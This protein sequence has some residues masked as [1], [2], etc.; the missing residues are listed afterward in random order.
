MSVSRHALVLGLLAAS[1]SPVAGWAQDNAAKT[2]LE[3]GRYWQAQGKPEQAQQSWEK[4]LLTDPAQPEALY[5]LAAIAIGKQQLPVAQGYLDRLRAAAPD[6]RFV[7][8]LEQDLRLAVEPGKSALEKARLM[9]KDASIQNDKAALAAAVTRYDQALGGKT[10][11]GSVAREYY[12]F[13]GYTDGGVDRAIQGL[14]RLNAEQPDNPAIMFPLAQH[15]ARDEGHR[16]EGIRLL[17]KLAA[18]PDIGGA[19]TEFWRLALTWMGAPRP[20]ERPFFESYLKLHPDDADIRRQML[21][22]RSAATAGGAPSNA[23]R[24][25][26]RLA[27]GFAALKRGDLVAAERAFADKLRESPDNADALGGLGV[28]RMQQNNLP[29]A[30]TLLSRA[31]SRPGAGAN[32]G[33]ALNSARYWNLVNQ[34]IASQNAG[35]LATARRQLD[36]ALRL[37]A[38]DPAAHNALGRLYAA[39][40]DLSSAEKA[41]RAVLAVDKDNSEAISGL[42]GVLAQSGRAD[43]AMQWINGMTPTQ[44]ANLGDLGR[45]RAAVAAGRAKAA[46][47]RGDQI[48][49]RRAL[50]D[51]LHDDPNNPWIRLE[52]AR[53]YL[54]N[55]GRAEARGLVD[56]LLASN[57]DMPDALYAS[58]LLAAQMGDWTKAQDAMSRIPASARTAAM[59]ATQQEIWIHVQSDRASKLARDGRRQEARALLAQLEPAAGQ[60]PALLG[61]IAQAYVDAGD[62]SRGLSLLRPL[63]PND[64]A[65]RRPDVLLPYAGLLLKGEQDVEAAGVLREL[66][67]QRLTSD[68][69]RQLDELNFLYTVRQAELRRQRGDLAGAYDTLAPALAKRPNDALVQGALARMYA[70]GGKY[71][72]A[73]D[74]YKQMI[75]RDPDNAT[76]QVSAAQVAAQA[77]ENRYADAALERA[78][79]TAPDD[80]DVLAAAARVYRMRGKSGKAASLLESAIVAKEKRQQQTQLAGVQ[81]GPAGL[82]APITAVPPNPFAAQ[83]TR[84]SLPPQAMASALENVPSQEDESRPAAPGDARQAVVLM[85]VPEPRLADVPPP[86]PATVSAM[87]S[88]R[89]PSAVSGQAGAQPTMQND[90][91]QVVAAAAVPESRPVLAPVPAATAGTAYVQPP[92]AA[93]SAIAAQPAGRGA[94]DTSSLDVMQ[95][96]LNDIRQERSPEVLAGMFVQSHSG[97]SGTSKLTT[98]QEPV[99]ARMP[100]GEG[101]LVVR[102]TP[103][104]LNA[105]GVG[106]DSSSASQFG[107]GPVAAL[108]QA[109]GIVGGPDTQRA[110]GVGLAAG[111]E[112]QGWKA[113]VGSTPFGFE[114]TNLVG[115]V[116]FNGPIDSHQGTWYNVGA[117]RRAVTDSL[118]SF[119]G[120]RDSRTGDSWG[121]VTA[122]G[123][124]GSVG[125]DRPA[126]G[127]YGYGSWQY[128]DGTNVASNTRSEVGAGTYWYL[129]RE[130]DSMLTA[131]LNLGGMFYNRNENF[132]TYG[133]GGYFS[134][135]QFYSLSIPI[136]WAERSGRFTYKLHGSIGI[137]HFNESQAAYF[138]TSSARQAAAVDAAAALGLGGGAMHPGQSNTGVGYSA[139]AAAE[140]RLASNWTLGGTVSIDNANSY[141]QWAGGLYLRYSFYPQ[142]TRQLE[143]PVVPYS[144]PYM[145]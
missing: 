94:T 2:L 79:A 135:Q 50:E 89:Q 20:E 6:S 27:R 103:V 74:L 136:N 123:V 32:W 93:G 65:A 55:G 80:P 24:Q 76:L 1:A 142:T 121:G 22:P 113:D 132:F 53:Y 68:Q 45:L 110:S 69:S 28:V 75:E 52:L 104:Q 128:L 122:S 26:P 61:G 19:A 86:V 125:M 60:N 38:R 131:G 72:Q 130:S 71:D 133:N 119:A 42:V 58:A 47:Q 14:Q 33:K 129:Q 51:A 5:G 96:E 40:G 10:P 90:T 118:L 73:L 12:T 41:F 107:G 137:Q 44:R 108:A 111:Y 3:Q 114:H 9:A 15:M 85:A 29:Q 101:K 124:Q 105:G 102:V 134:P 13:L 70:D 97:T 115:G 140:Y 23:P 141:R 81:S 37:D 11:Q 25:D 143:M 126:Y 106:G 4:L 17:E 48:T 30:E 57:P 46:E 54:D 62:Y 31:A 109:S 95:S 36:Q 127:V 116:E 120:T 91:R 117:S 35:D 7:P 8:L 77:Q 39:Q 138:P 56:G 82:A 49:A 16:A 112:A 66:Q 18:R 92:V 21:Q 84:P 63:L 144:S 88:T 99:E 100:V 59:A 67:G 43:Q 78:V 64:V 87:D 34:G 98:L 83:A 139:L 145:R